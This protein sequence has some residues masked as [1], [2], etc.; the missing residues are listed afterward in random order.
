MCLWTCSSSTK[1]LNI[2]VKFD[3]QKIGDSWIINLSELRKLTPFSKEESFLRNFMKVKQVSEIFSAEIIMHSPYIFFLLLLVDSR[4]RVRNAFHVRVTVWMR[5][6]ACSC[7]RGKWGNKGHK[8][9][10][11]WSTDE[12]SILRIITL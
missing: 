12:G 1:H 11:I 7:G 10:I 2:H 4:A 3:L 5:K 6:N 8:S 9:S